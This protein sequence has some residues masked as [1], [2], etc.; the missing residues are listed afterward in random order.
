MIHFIKYLSQN[1]DKDF[2]RMYRNKIRSNR[3]DE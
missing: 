2:V 1:F 3:I